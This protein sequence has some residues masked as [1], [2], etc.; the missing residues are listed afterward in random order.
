LE[1]QSK[2]KLE[3]AFLKWELAC[4]VALGDLK[5]KV[6]SRTR[7]QYALSRSKLLESSEIFSKKVISDSVISQESLLQQF[8]KGALRGID[9]CLKDGHASDAIVLELKLQE[10]VSLA[11]LL[12]QKH[13]FILKDYTCTKDDIAKLSIS[14]R[15]WNNRIQEIQQFHSP[16]DD[17]GKRGWNFFQ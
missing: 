15:S 13:K 2:V 5:A 8:I 3:E 14:L 17:V 7:F 4:A 12:Q 6:L 10:I 1:I 9:A 16:V 11:Y